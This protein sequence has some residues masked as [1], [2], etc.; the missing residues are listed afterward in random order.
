MDNTLIGKQGQLV[1]MENRELVN[2]T[3]GRF[4]QQ[5]KLDNKSNCPTVRIGTGRIGQ[6][7]LKTVLEYQILDGTELETACT[8]TLRIRTHQKPRT[9]KKSKQQQHGLFDSHF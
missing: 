5:P 3:I 7:E 8:N 4:R 2:W 1:T 9:L 6:R